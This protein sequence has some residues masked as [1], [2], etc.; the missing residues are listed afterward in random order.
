MPVMAQTPGG[1]APGIADVV[2]AVLWGTMTERF[3]KIAKMFDK[4]AALTRR[5][6]AL[7]PLAALTAKARDDYGDAYCGGQIEKS[8]RKMLGE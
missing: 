1:E 5:V 6:S 7:Q 2:T 3:R 4:T 8:L